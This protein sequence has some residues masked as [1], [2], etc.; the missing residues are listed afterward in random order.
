[1]PAEFQSLFYL[2]S[3]CDFAV[4]STLVARVQSFN[5]CSI[6]IRS[7]IVGEL[8]ESLGRVMF[9]SLFYLDSVCDIPIIPIN[10]PVSSFNP[11]SIWIRSVIRIE[12]P[13]ENVAPCFNP[14]SIW[15]RSVIV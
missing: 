8:F 9:Q 5:P 12:S 7:V 4:S 14:C 11:C 3:V 10:R 6:W 13:A 2:D 15:I 1:M